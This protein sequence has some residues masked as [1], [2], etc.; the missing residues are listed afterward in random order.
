MLILLLSHTQGK[1]RRRRSCGW[2][3]KG[4]FWRQKREDDISI[5]VVFESSLRENERTTVW[6]SWREVKAKKSPAVLTREEWPPLLFPS[7]FP[8]SSPSSRLT[9]GLLSRGI[10]LLPLFSIALASVQL[11]RGV[12][13]VAQLGTLHTGKREKKMDELKEGVEEKEK[14]ARWGRAKSVIPRRKSLVHTN[15][16]LPLR[17]HTFFAGCKFIRHTTRLRTLYKT[18]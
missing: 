16:F 6:K 15:I 11:L 17:L 5:F 9:N 8:T 12:L 1:R 14:S 2:S 13:Y 3:G 7:L 4:C 18:P 10:F